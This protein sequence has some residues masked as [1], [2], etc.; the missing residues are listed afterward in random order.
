LQ[1]AVETLLQAFSGPLGRA[2][3]GLLADMARDE[4]LAHMIRQRVL[5]A[6]RNSMRE[7]FARA[8]ARGEA[9]T[10]LDIELLIDML[11]GP[12]YYRVLF[13]HVPITRKAA[14][15]AVEYVLRVARG[16]RE[17]RVNRR[18]HQ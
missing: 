15:E 11:T 14:E 9:R 4:E 18:S 3:P 17:K 8:T 13:R 12:F 2:L 16:H 1:A 7:A 5:A 6:R 10:D